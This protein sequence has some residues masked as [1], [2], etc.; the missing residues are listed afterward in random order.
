MNTNIL[1]E[2]ATIPIKL[3]QMFNRFMN[4]LNDVLNVPSSEQIMNIDWSSLTSIIGTISLILIFTTLAI[5]VLYFIRSIGLYTLARD[6][7]RSFAWLAFIPFGCFFIY[8]IILKR[9][10]IFGVDV[11][12]PEYLLP[13]LLLSSFLPYVGPFATFLF[14]I[15]KLGLLYRLYE[16]KT[17]K[18]ATLFLVLSIFI[19]L[20]EPFIIYG[21]SKK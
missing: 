21:I 3:N 9:T 14:I 17:P 5:L 13:A 2:T 7:N 10:R 6:N 16:M 19:P 1:N 15:C 12:H 20:A 4:W 11:D 8:G 18:Y